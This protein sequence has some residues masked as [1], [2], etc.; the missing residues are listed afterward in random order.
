MDQKMELKNKEIVYF[1]EEPDFKDIQKIV[2]GYFTIIP[3]SSNKTMFVNEEGELRQLKINKKAT[4][5]V[6]YTIYGNVLI[7]GSA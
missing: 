7:V 5:M 6:G 4:E 2:G 3:L 1:D